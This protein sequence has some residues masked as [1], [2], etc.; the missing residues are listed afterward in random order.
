MTNEPPHFGRML[1]AGRESLGISQRELAKQIGVSNN[2]ICMVESGRVACL[3]FRAASRCAR[4]LG[5]P[6]SI[7]VDPDDERAV[8]K[9]AGVKAS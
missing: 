1:K 7:F 9:L 4:A 2:V 6:L 5:L 3:S 8:R